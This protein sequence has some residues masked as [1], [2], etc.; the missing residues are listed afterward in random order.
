MGDTGVDVF[1]CHFIDSSFPAN[2]FSTGLG[3]E[4]SG[5]LYFD[6]TRHRKIR[7]YRMFEDNID[8]NG[9]GSHCAGSAVGS[10][11]YGRVLREKQK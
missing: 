9:H 2:A 10:P 1:H 8:A 5:V 7:Y 3:R 4:A 11:Q 6:S